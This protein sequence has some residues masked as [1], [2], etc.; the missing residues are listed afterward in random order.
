MAKQT[1]GVGASANDGTGDSLRVAWQKQNANNTELYALLEPVYYYFN[2][3]TV[4]FR[5]ASGDLYIDKTI[6]ATGFDGTENT[7]WEAIAKLT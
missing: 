4:R 5:F 2:G 6:T 3:R 7:D 1:I